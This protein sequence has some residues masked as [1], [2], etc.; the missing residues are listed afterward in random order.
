[1][2]GLNNVIF[3][4]IDTDLTN[5]SVT[6]VDQNYTGESLTPIP[7]V[8]LNE[9]TI[10]SENY[11]V[12]YSNNINAGIASVSVT[13]K[14]DYIGS[15]IGTFTINKITPVYTAPTAKTLTYNGNAQDL[16]NAGSTN[17]GTIEYS[18]DETNWSQTIP[19][20][21]NA[22]PYTLY[23]RL[24]GDN[25]HT[26]IDSQSISVSIAK[27]VPVVVAPTAKANLV[28]DGS[29]QALANAGSATFGSLQYSLDGTN[30]STA[31]PTGT[32][33]SDYTVYYK[34]V[35]DNN[36]YDVSPLTISCSI[37]K[38]APSYVAPTAKSLTYNGNSQQLLNAGSTSEGTIQYSADGSEWNSSIPEG[39]NADDY[40]SYWKLIGDSNHT[41]VSSTSVATTIIKVTPTV[42]APTVKILTFDGTDQELVNAA[43]TDWGTLKYSL[44]NSSWATT[45]PT[46]KNFGTYTV[47]Y[48][49]DGNSN[50]NNVASASIQASIAEKR[51]TNPTIILSQDVYTYSGNENQPI[52]TVKDGDVVI[53]SSEYNVSYSNNVNAGTATVTISDNTD[54]NY[55]VIGSTTFTINKVT[56]TVTAPTAKTDLVYS[57]SAQTLANAGSTNW[58]TLQY[59]SDNTNW[60]TMIPSGTNASTSYKVYYRVVGNANI[61]DVAS[62]N[63]TC[64]IAKAN[65]SASVSM[66]G[67][68]YGGTAT[69]PSVSGNSGSGN[70][71]YSYKTKYA[72][73]TTYTETKP[74]NA[75][76]Y[77]VRAIIEETAN[78]NG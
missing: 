6:A 1:M 78:Y 46:G 42:G 43:T 53:P 61:N 15:T 10:G 62:S 51:V 21:T 70:V 66:A 48:K 73:N 19:Q 68:T 8:V 38:A 72:A 29:A 40:T 41:D 58:G 9:R 37:A 27:V 12:V 52:P 39:T 54:G 7:T 77:V 60:S 76:T 23:W 65:L 24:V 44:D 26:D 34:V 56:P 36:I 14:G 35:G 11:D 59:S 18:T 16:L 32:D 5:A 31:I 33:A 22:T 74:S 20:G 71:T 69:S 55:Y 64:T 3:D 17:H 25:N 75:G 13:G 4:Y 67:W 47:Y 50:I 30:Y 28:Y 45:I 49:V 63:I 57:G 2:A